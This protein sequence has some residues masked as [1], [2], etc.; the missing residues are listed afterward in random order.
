MSDFDLKKT[1]FEL[2]AY[3]RRR[4]ERWRD[5]QVNRA[6]G[7]ARTA[8]VTALQTYSQD[9][10][11]LS[12]KVKTAEDLVGTWDEIEALTLQLNA[13]AQPANTIL[14][15][16]LL[17][18]ID[19]SAEDYLIPDPVVLAQLT[20]QA[21]QEIA[22]RTE[23]FEAA[24]AR[25]QA[26]L[27]RTQIDLAVNLKELLPNERERRAAFLREFR[28]ELRQLRDQVDK[29]PPDCADGTAQ[30]NLETAIKSTYL[31]QLRKRETSFDVN[32][33]PVIRAKVQRHRNEARYIVPLFQEGRP[34]A[35]N[36]LST[37]FLDSDAHQIDQ[38]VNGVMTV[39]DADGSIVLQ[40][41]RFEDGGGFGFEKNWY[42][43]SNALRKQVKDA[44][45]LSDDPIGQDT[46]PN[47]LSGRSTFCFIDQIKLSQTANDALRSDAQL[48]LAGNTNAVQHQLADFVSRMRGLA[49]TDVDLSIFAFEGMADFA[50]LP[51][52]TNWLSAHTKRRISLHINEVGLTSIVIKREDQTRPDR[53]ERDAINMIRLLAL[54]VV[55]IADQAVNGRGAS[56]RNYPKRLASDRHRIEIPD[57]CVWPL[58]IK[59]GQ[60]CTFSDALALADALANTDPTCTLVN[61][62]MFGWDQVPRKAA[63][64]PELLAWRFHMA[65][66]KQIRTMET[67]PDAT[68][69][70]REGLNSHAALTRLVNW[71][72]WTSLV[73][74]A[75]WF[76]TVI[77][78]TYFASY[79]SEREL[80]LFSI[81]FFL[82]ALWRF[83]LVS[84]LTSTGRQRD[85]TGARAT[86]WNRLRYQALNLS[87]MRR[88]NLLLGPV[89]LICMSMAITALKSW[90]WLEVFPQPPQVPAD[91]ASFAKAMKTAVWAL[92]IVGVGLLRQAYV[93]LA[94]LL[95]ERGRIRARERWLDALE[96]NWKAGTSLPHANGLA[97][98]AAVK[99][100]IA[101]LHARFAAQ[102][103]RVVRLFGEKSATNGVLVA[104]VTLLDP[105]NGMAPENGLDTE[106]TALML[107]T[108]NPVPETLTQHASRKTARPLAA[109]AIP[110]T[111]TPDVASQTAVSPCDAL[112]EAGLIRAAQRGSSFIHQSI[113]NANLIKCHDVSG[114]GANVAITELQAALAQQH[115]HI[116]G[117]LQSIERRLEAGGRQPIQNTYV[118]MFPYNRHCIQGSEVAVS[119]EGLGTV[120]FDFDAFMQNVEA[121]TDALDRLAKSRH[122]TVSADTG[123][124]FGD[125]AVANEVLAKTTMPRTVQIDARTDEATEKI[126]D[127]RSLIASLPDTHLIHV[128]AD[129][130]S[131]ITALMA[132]LTELQE[133]HHQSDVTLDV[134]K[135]NAMAKLRMVLIKLQ[136]IRSMDHVTLRANVD[137]LYQEIG[138]ARTLIDSFPERRGVW[139]SGLLPWQVLN[140]EMNVDGDGGTGP[141]L[142]KCDLLASRKFAR[143]AP[144]KA[145][146]G[147]VWD[148]KLW[149]FDP[150]T[151][152]ANAKD[153][154]AKV[155]AGD[156]GGKQIYVLGMT[157]GQGAPAH[158]SLLSQT[159]AD[160]VVRAVKDLNLDIIP[161]SLSI[162]E[163]G[164]LTRHG[165]PNAEE[166]PDRR[167]ALI[168]ACDRPAKTR[169]I[170]L[171]PLR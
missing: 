127:V 154:L 27:T 109:G 73:S 89:V 35:R 129:V 100:Q 31:K 132:V 53:P 135:D 167:A 163:T 70:D 157:D 145:P 92:P 136:E 10:E 13:A 123:P 159:R 54:F 37:T 17:N 68:M 152:G 81:A 158:N 51:H 90:G 168:Y 141:N 155:L 156:Q 166:D 94:Q 15:T 87:L 40:T 125:V 49:N 69:G 148:K 45:N 165:L 119:T 32:E 1:V 11:A 76:V 2:F 44:Q 112:T 25:A 33:A 144:L 137:S 140:I 46:V 74:V 86:W 6:I 96:T 139:L 99:D 21:A 95:Q 170:D 12:T 82:I 14:T 63:S 3:T 115:A 47:E 39:L 126:K 91:G 133:I 114:A 84:G 88:W 101:A 18:N 120:A 56:A 48:H 79:F 142:G 131:A 24:L 98:A 65:T 34:V 80:W 106:E 143:N 58:Q 128:R 97:I 169:G 26:T 5:T 19:A 8:A 36:A 41:R 77:T 64:P 138:R 29:T 171:G 22:Q 7:R 116:L 42:K 118:C 147:D 107:T 117:A 108:L 30:A 164:W 23:K 124:L 113:L 146:G 16:M 78:T 149:R 130:E 43:V 62:W 85:V 134:K 28:S 67:V 72:A 153:K 105:L 59:V 83:I 110:A 122:V 55:A 93:M 121:A 161:I 61:E 75:I 52:I 57:L 50:A 102:R 20:T 160:F 38:M 162:G 111:N 150:Q 71:F 9:R 60:A 4:I 103:A 151:S 104:L 66:Q